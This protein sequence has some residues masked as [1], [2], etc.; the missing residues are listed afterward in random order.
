MSQNLIIMAEINFLIFSF[1]VGLLSFFNPCGSAVLVS[2]LVGFF[3]KK[4]IKKNSTKRV[5]AAISGGIF[6]TLGLLTVFVALGLIL[7]VFGQTLALYIPY[8]VALLGAFLIVVGISL[9]A[10]KNFFFS[11]PV[12]SSINLNNSFGF[13]KYGMM[14]SLASFACNLPLFLTVIF[15]AIALGT[16]DDSALAFVAYGIAAGIAMTVVMILAA[17]TKE[18]VMKFFSKILQHVN[19]INAVV[20]ILV[21]IYL[22]VF[23]FYSGNILI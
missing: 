2:Y 23:Q 16:L 22:I 10:H 20:L 11:I 13:Y 17:S 9:L 7:T 12:R 6:A 18:V 14:Y 4:E 5:L 15:G 19:T 1:F 8:F 3:S 21:G